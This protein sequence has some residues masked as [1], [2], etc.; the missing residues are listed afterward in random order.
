MKLLQRQFQASELVLNQ[1][2]A[3]RLSPAASPTANCPRLSRKQIPK[4]EYSFML[5]HSIHVQASYNSEQK[6][7]LS[8]LTRS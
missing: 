2:R 1:L 7:T 4:L 6:P 5:S 8:A 3:I